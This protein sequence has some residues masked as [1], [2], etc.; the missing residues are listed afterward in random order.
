LYCENSEVTEKGY[1]FEI[2]NYTPNNFCLQ[3]ISTQ[4]KAN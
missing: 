3:E 4:L 2:K 1:Q